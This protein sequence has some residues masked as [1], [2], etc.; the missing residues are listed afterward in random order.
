MDHRILGAIGVVAGLA[1]AAPAVAQAPAPVVADKP[2]RGPLK[3][4]LEEAEKAITKLTK[5]RAD[6]EIKLAFA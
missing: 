2:K 5:E 4:A 1:S 6:I 3:R